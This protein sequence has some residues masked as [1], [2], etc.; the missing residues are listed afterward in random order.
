LKIDGSK[1]AGTLSGRGEA[2]AIKGEVEN[3]KLTFAMLN[4]QQDDAVYVGDIKGS[5]LVGTVEA[6]EAGMVHRLS[7]TATRPRR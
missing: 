1:V 6:S 7:W 5:V 3:G 2:R 4:A